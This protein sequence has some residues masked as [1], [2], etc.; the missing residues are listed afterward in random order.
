MASKRSRSPR[1]PS[2]ALTSRANASSPGRTACSKSR[3][4][5]ALPR[6]P[7]SIALPRRSKSACSPTWHA[8]HHATVDRGCGGARG[9]AYQIDGDPLARGRSQM[10]SRSAMDL[11]AGRVWRVRSR[12]QRIVD[13]DQDFPRRAVRCNPPSCM[14]PETPRRRSPPISSFRVPRP[15]ARSAPASTGAGA[16]GRN[17]RSIL[18]LATARPFASKTAEQTLILNG[19][20]Q[21]RRWPRRISR[22]STEPSLT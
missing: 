11:G 4:R 1:R 6:S 5:R 8:Q 9:Q 20:T 17:G 7:I 15:T 18:R 12:H 21:R 14:V 3:R 22:T 10:A 19:E 2:R 16:K 13:R